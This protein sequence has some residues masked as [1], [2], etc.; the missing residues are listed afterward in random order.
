MP[1]FFLFEQF[2]SPQ[3]VRYLD[4]QIFGIRCVRESYRGAAPA[5]LPFFI[6]QS[7]PVPALV[8]Y[9]I[10]SFNPISLVKLVAGITR[11]EVRMEISGTV[12]PDEKMYF[13]FIRSKGEKMDISV[14]NTLEGYLYDI[15]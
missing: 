15:A 1:R 10:R 3:Q 12:H 6:G 9:E 2:Y 5:V 8:T 11:I 14:R 4:N 13:P 7:E